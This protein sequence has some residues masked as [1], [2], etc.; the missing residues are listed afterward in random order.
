VCENLKNA[1]QTLRD[2]VARDLVAPELGA[3]EPAASVRLAYLDAHVGFVDTVIGRMV[4]PLT[5]EMRARDLTAIRVE[6]YKELPVDRSGFI[7]P[8]PAIEAMELCDRFE[9]YVARKLYVHNCGH[10]VLAYL[11]YLRGYAYG[12][13]A[14]ADPEIAAHLDRA[15]DE[16]IAGQVAHYG[17]SAAW[18]REHAVALRQRFANRALGDTVYRLGRDPIRKLGPTDRLVAPARLAQAA[19]VPPRSLA[20]AIAAALCFD[21]PQDQIAVAL[22]QQLAAQGLDAVLAQVSQIEPQST[23]ARLIREQIPAL[24]A[25]RIPAAGEARGNGAARTPS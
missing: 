10:A 22:Q 6:P 1:G 2:L 18:L 12:Y 16:S 14:L 9:T 23:L 11:G 20:R 25:S 17:V 5:P 15:W 4:P 13:Q 24:R 21:P 8:P 7:G 3:R 19:G